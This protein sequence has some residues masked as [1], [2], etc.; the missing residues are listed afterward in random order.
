MASFDV[1]AVTE[2]SDALGKVTVRI[3]QDVSS[4]SSLVYG[5]EFQM[6]S[7]E[8]QVVYQGHGTDKDI[9]VASA[10][11]YMN[12]INKLMNMKTNSLQVNRH[13]EI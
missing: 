5:E 6:G 4:T 1:K 11:A 2:G 13:V 7:H 12:A 3:M 10:K 9:L 8:S